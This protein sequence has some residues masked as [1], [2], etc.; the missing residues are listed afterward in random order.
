MNKTEGV[1]KKIE[2][3]HCVPLVH[4]VRISITIILE[5]AMQKLL[6]AFAV[7][8]M[9]LGLTAC[10]TTVQTVPQPM[11]MGPPSGQPVD[12]TANSL[13]TRVGSDV[14]TNKPENTFTAASA[15]PVGGAF[16]K[17][18]DTVDKTKMSRALDKTI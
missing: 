6:I 3:I 12:A 1:I 11:P 16:I 10:S 13:A 2:S 18:M 4:G 15:A 5:S 8:V 7:I 9:T 14:S 17:S